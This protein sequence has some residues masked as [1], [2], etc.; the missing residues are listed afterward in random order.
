MGTSVTV[1]GTNFGST[2][3]TSTVTFNGTAATPANWS[4]TSIVVPVPSAATSGNVVVT[5]AG[6]ASNGSSFVVLVTPEISNLAPTA[7][8]VGTPVTITGTNFGATQGSSTV[9]FNGTAATPSSWSGTSIVVP[10]PAGAS[11]GPVSVTVGGQTAYSPFFTVGTLP[12]G[13]T[14]ADVGTVDVAGN[15]SYANGIFTLSGA[16]FQFSGTEDAFHFVYQPLSGNGSII[17]RV[18]MPFG[19]GAQA[20]VMIR[21]SLDGASANGN[22]VIPSAAIAEF[23]VRTAA[24]GPTS[25]VGAISTGPSPYWVELVRSGT[26][27]SSYASPDGLNWTL[28]ANQTINMPTNVYVGLVV[29]SGI[30]SSL[31]TV[32]FDNVSVNS[33]AAPAPV[34]T[35]VS[36]TTGAIGSTVVI[37]GSNFGAS[38]EGSV[39]TLNAAPVTI[40]SW[41][42]TS[43][44]ITIPSGATS[45]LL[46]VSVAPSMNDSNP[47]VF[48]VTS[49]PLLSGWLD[50]MWAL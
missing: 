6:Q 30:P 12:A 21:E 22:T 31:A 5:V 36:A 24:G 3:G 18:T 2:Q 39:V 35:S 34:I 4:A 7:G 45:G 47:I 50:E 49:S 40:N 37:T 10:V 14:D 29:D 23:N 9:A 20:G 28:V 1:T 27:F 13:W 48:T 38:Q 41:S 46:V 26:T 42:N 44:S 16:G 19:T 15:S 11:S 17:A 33:S 43:I 32:T 8:Q 25:S